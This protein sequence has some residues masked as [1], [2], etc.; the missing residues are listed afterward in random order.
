MSDG[1]TIDDLVLS[2]AQAEAAQRS[3]AEMVR[4]FNARRTVA[5]FDG[6]VAGAQPGA[7][8]VYGFGRNAATDCPAGVRDRMWALAAAGL[9]YLF[10]PR[11]VRADGDTNFPFDFTAIR[12]SKPLPGAWPNLP[13]API[14]TISSTQARLAG[15]ALSSSNTGRG[16]E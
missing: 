1:L 7:K 15:R 2:P 8:Q 6:W 9:V 4:R 5:D 11:V 16:D 12:S 13:A 3:T 10:Q 14:S